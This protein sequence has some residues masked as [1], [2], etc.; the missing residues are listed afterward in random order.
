[1]NYKYRVYHK[2]VLHVW[3]DGT[4]KEGVRLYDAR[5]RTKAA[6]IALAATLDLGEVRPLGSNKVVW[7]NG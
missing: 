1:M 4:V 3:D 5:N 2:T 6:A 7:S